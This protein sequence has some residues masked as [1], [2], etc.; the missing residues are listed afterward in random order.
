[1]EQNILIIGT[2]RPRHLLG[3]H[4]LYSEYMVHTQ[5]QTGLQC[6]DIVITESVD[7]VCRDTTDTQYML[8]QKN[9]S[10]SQKRYTYKP[11]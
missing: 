7:S 10:K 11:L 1:M 6:T 4:E 9:L 3:S 2:Y 8:I 5:L